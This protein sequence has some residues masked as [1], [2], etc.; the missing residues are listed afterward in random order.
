MTTNSNNGEIFGANALTFA[1]IAGAAFLMLA[2]ITAPIAVGSAASAQ[3]AR[4]SIET[5]VVTA[6]RLAE[7][8]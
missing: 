6:P 8:S 7:N 1:I 3:A 4:P 2:S 5:A